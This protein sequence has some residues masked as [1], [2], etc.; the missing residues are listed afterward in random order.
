MSFRAQYGEKSAKILLGGLLP[1]LLIL[2]CVGTCVGYKKLKEYKRTREKHV[3][4]EMEKNRLV[5]NSHWTITASEYRE[6]V[7][8]RVSQVRSWQFTF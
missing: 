2:G 7:Y 3:Y 5:C 8:V 4:S 1:L 6:S